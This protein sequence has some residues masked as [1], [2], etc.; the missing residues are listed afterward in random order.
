M[1]YS[2]L[3]GAQKITPFIWTLWMDIVRQ[4]P[5]SVLWLLNED[6]AIQNRL[7]EAAVQQGV[8]ADRLIFAARKLN[9]DHVARFPLA[10]LTIDS[11]PYGSHTTASDALWMGVPVLTLAGLGFAARVCGSLVKAAGLE[12][13]ICY[14]PE[15]YVTKAVALGQD[16]GR[17]TEYR[18][19]LAAHRDTCPL[20]DTPALVSRLEQLYAKMWSA[21]RQGRLPRPDLSNLEVY[22]EIGIELDN[23]GV[24][25]A[26]D[27]SYRAQYRAK[28]IEKDRYAFIRCDNRLWTEA[29]RAS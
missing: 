28:L 9:A 20:F 17:L 19:R 12:E 26:T 24:G 1:V 7:R 14:S 3:N 2:C 6:E 21:F 27:A 22:Q 4:V 25:M 15:E 11:A 16:R 13:L 29:D 8:T 5:G 23:G 18:Q 10:D